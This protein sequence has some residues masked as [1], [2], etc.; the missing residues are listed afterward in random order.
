M[1]AQ[2]P[3]V[4]FLLISSAQLAAGSTLQVSGPVTSASRFIPTDTQMPRCLGLLSDTP[5]TAEM[6]KHFTLR[7][8]SPTAI[9]A[10]Q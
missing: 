1:G 6:Q 10:K 7:L 8:M 4:P 5:T 2:L 3:W 9:D